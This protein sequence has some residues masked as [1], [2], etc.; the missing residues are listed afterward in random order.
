MTHR[1]SR[2]AVLSALLVFALGGTLP[3]QTARPA[4]Q[5]VIARGAD[6]L[7]GDPTID[8]YNV[9]T[10]V[11][12][13]VCDT[14]VVFGEGGRLEPRIAESWKAED[15]K[16][17]VFKLRRD[18][19]F[20]DGTPVTAQD[21]KFTLD[22]II[23]PKTKSAMDADFAPIIASS[24]VPDP[25]TLR[26]NLKVPLVPFVNQ[27][28]FVFVISKRAFERMGEKEFGKKPVCSGPYKFT[29]WV[30]NDRVVLDAFDGYYRGT[31]KIQRV[32]YRTIPE[33][34]TRV[35]ALRAGEVDLVEAVP[36]D[37]I[38]TVENAPNLR[39]ERAPSGRILFFL[40]Y[41][42]DGP[43]KD[44]RVRQ[45][46]NYAIDWDAISK[47]VF[48]GNARKAPSPILPHVFGYKSVVR[49]FYDVE[50]AKRMLA[51]AGYASGFAVT[52]E[53]PNGRYFRDRELAQA[54]AGYLQQVG[55]RVDLRTYEWG[56]YL[57]RYR[58][59]QVRLG[60]FGYLNIFRD[61]DDI[62]LHFEPDRRG[63]YWNDATVTRLFREGRSTTDASRRK[64]TYSKLLDVIMEEAPWLF[65]VEIA[66]IYG[67]NNR[68][69]WKPIPGTD[70][71]GM[72]GATVK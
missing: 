62:A 72:Y 40:M 60:L 58:G 15:P 61:F 66:N 49:Y 16:T 38:R 64:A 44:K 33:A 52:M 9:H 34:S 68:L 57:R 21:A 13:N 51:E 2:Y 29:E 32:I 56:E 17:Y 63:I 47:A 23:D 48:G 19:K 6:I 36:P 53:S 54:V 41:A 20:H 71:Y 67:V 12:L 46:L 35:A 8:A 31:T 59:R 42:W 3:A 4:S 69:Q 5:V 14:L 70:N 45:A 65:G 24:E 50:R 27:M 37:Q 28:P 26:I 1:L 11:F 18:V 39:I 10:S 22:R 25:Y 7:T 30:P 43:F 55:V